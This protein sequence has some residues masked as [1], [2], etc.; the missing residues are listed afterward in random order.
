MQT[1][2]FY[3]QTFCQIPE[4]DNPAFGD[5][6]CMMIVKEVGGERAVVS[7][8]K[9]DPVEAVNHVAIFWD[10]SKAMEYC[11]GTGQKD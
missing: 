3:P 11:N 1:V 4:Q 7:R 8:I 2:N 5:D 9:P 6:E 10:H